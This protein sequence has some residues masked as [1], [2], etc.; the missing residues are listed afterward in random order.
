MKYTDEQKAVDAVVGL[1]AFLWIMFA[2][3]MIGLAGAI[4]KAIL[5]AFGID[6][7]L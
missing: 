7:G 3:S 4:L 6:I 2:A 1:M 5:M